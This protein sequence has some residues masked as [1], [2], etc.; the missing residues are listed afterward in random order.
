VRADVPGAALR[1]ELRENSKDL[2]YLAPVGQ[3]SQ[4]ITLTTSWQEVTVTYATT[5]T[6]VGA[7]PNFTKGSTLD[8]T[9]YID[10]AP[11]GT[12]FYADDAAIALQPAPVAALTV[13][14][15]HGVAPM[16]VHADASAS[17][18]TDLPIASYTFDFGDGTIV[19]PQPEPTA[20]H[21][22]F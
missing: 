12:C 8:L 16:T 14:P 7:G 17:R 1:L 4:R 11:P 6:P 13:T 22:Y 21:T 5:A 10:N 2:P 9:A 3:A 19:G 15:T 18:V 20:D